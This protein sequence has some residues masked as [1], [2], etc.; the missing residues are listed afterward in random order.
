MQEGDADFAMQMY[1]ATERTL[2]YRSRL[3]SA[4]GG[5]GAHEILQS[6]IT[7]QRDCL[8]AVAL[9]K[10]RQGHRDDFITAYHTLAKWMEDPTDKLSR[11][12]PQ[13]YLALNHVVLLFPIY[14]VNPHIKKS[15]GYL[16]P[17]LRSFGDSHMD[18][19]AAILER[20]STP[21]K[22]ATIEDLP[23]EEC[24]IRTMKPRILDSPSGPMV[25]K[26]PANFVRYVDIEDLARLTDGTKRNINALQEEHSMPLTL[27]DPPA[28]R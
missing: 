6:E 20:C 22:D 5:P 7:L 18:H 17:R 10:L 28:S 23:I 21:D 26:K 11:V 16:I 24:S 8:L 27:F 14:G 12:A 13:A 2:A 4:L 1:L 3:F 15:V 19:D 9:G 25:P